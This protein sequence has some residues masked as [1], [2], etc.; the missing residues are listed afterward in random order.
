MH[1][2]CLPEERSVS[3]DKWLPIVR[4]NRP[5]ASKFTTQ[6]GPASKCGSAPQQTA[7][8]RGALSLASQQ[9][10]GSRDLR[11]SQS[12]EECR[13]GIVVRC[14]VTCARGGQMTSCPSASTPS[15]LTLGRARDIRRYDLRMSDDTPRRA[16]TLRRRTAP[17]STIYGSTHYLRPF[18]SRVLFLSS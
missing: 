10:N 18:C 12:D 17:P 5:L 14:T 8:R 2:T 3:R 13:D 6:D 15:H 1:K 9:S 4:Y 11:T 16:A 7:E